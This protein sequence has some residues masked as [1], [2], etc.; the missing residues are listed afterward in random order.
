MGTVFM[1]GQPS[2]RAICN[3]VADEQSSPHPSC[4]VGHGCHGQFGWDN[5]GANTKT[6]CSFWVL[7]ELKSVQ[8]VGW[9]T[10]LHQDA[11]YCLAMK[12]LVSD[13]CVCGNRKYRDHFFAFKML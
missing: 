8:W 3:S 2:L 11:Q 12:R 13:V 5:T 6:N 4:N 7:L 1:P 9:I 10:H